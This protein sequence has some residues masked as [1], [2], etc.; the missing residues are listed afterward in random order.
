M[1]AVAEKLK[2]IDDSIAFMVVGDGP[3]L[4]EIQKR[5]KEKNLEET[6]F[7]AGRQQDLRPFYKDS[8]ITL[9]CSIKE[10]LALTAYESCSM[11]V[12]VISSDVGGQG[13][14]INKKTGALLPVMQE[15]TEIGNYNYSDKEIL[16]YVDSI[17]GILSDREA[18]K[19][20]CENCRKS[21]EEKFSL[22]IMIGKM[23]REFHALCRDEQFLEKRRISN[24]EL[25]SYQGILEEFVTIYNECELRDQEMVHVWES[26]DWLKG[27][28]ENLGAALEARSKENE[29]L[30]EEKANVLEEKGRIETD[31]ENC[32]RENQQLLVYKEQLD[33]ILGSKSWKV[34]QKYIHFMETSFIGKIIS[35]IRKH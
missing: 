8:D 26:C 22:D 4:G 3:M 23:E 16:Q 33:G 21:I 25:K 20:L 34:C 27:Q 15:E 13:E 19:I 31:Y 30:F 32:L 10:G 18:Y 14:L 1:L 24:L 9:I 7:F 17:L 29:I 11:G 2:L 28:C 12:P 35:K 5:V 6:V